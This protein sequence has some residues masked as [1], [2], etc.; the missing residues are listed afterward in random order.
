[1]L[2]KKPSRARPAKTEKQEFTFE[3]TLIRNRAPQ[4]YLGIIINEEFVVQQ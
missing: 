4:N 3:N 2:D 1:M